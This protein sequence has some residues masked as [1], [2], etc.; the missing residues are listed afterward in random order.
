MILDKVSNKFEL[1]PG[2]YTF[3]NPY[4]YTISRKF[5]DINMFRKVY[6]DGFLAVMVF[7]LLGFE[8]DRLSFDMTSV[9]PKVF[10]W[11]IQNNKSIAFI[12]SKEEDILKAVQ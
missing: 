5:I 10:L 12:G 2:L 11:C 7:K 9:A 6:V 3:V 1:N 8:C 4:S